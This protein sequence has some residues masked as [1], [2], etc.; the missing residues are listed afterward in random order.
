MAENPNENETASVLRELRNSL[1]WHRE[2]LTAGKAVIVENFL[3]LSF[4]QAANYLFPLIFL[5]YLLRVVGYEKYGLIAFAQSLVV[6]FVTLTDYGFNLSATRDISLHKDDKG[7]VSQIFLSVLLI[8]IVLMLVG[9]AIFSCIVFMIAKFA[10]N[11]LLYFFTFG[12]VLGRV[13]FP[14]WFFQGIEQMKYITVATF[15]EKLTFT[16]LLFVFIRQPSQYLYVPLLISIGAVVSGVVGLTVAMSKIQTRQTFPQWKEI[17]VQ[18][19]GG[20]HVFISTVSVNAYTATRVFAVGLFANPAITGAYALAEKL[21]SVIQTFPLASLLR[22]LFPRLTDLYGKN[23]ARCVRLVQALQRYT[24]F[25]HMILLPPIIFFAPFIVRVVSGA[26]SPQAVAALRVLLVAV[27]VINANA[28]R[29]QF[30][31]VAGLDRFYSRIHVLT[32]S[33]GI[34][35]IFLSAYYFSY[36]GPAVS[37]VFIE[38]I[39][40]ILTV[41]ALR[42]SHVLEELDSRASRAG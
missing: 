20:W 37:L 10:A 32:S 38:S 36:M 29:I 41:Y 14:V 15:A 3:S 31:L 17:A 34:V 1:R 18:L 26:T 33:V 9:L 25:A 21:M 2:P 39:A 22:A 11:W 4:L 40:L 13:L 28:F 30:V 6:Y 24:I 42:Q 12:V 8:K 19:K 35:A 16:L 27:F 5:P 23:R 7:K